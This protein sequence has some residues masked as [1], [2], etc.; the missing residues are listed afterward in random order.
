MRGLLVA[1]GFFCC[2]AQALGMR[3]SVA[4]ARRLQGTG[5]AAVTHGLS[6]SAACGIFPGQGSNPCPC[7]GRW[8][9]NHSAT[10]EAQ[11]LISFKLHTILSSLMKSCAACSSSPRIPNHSCHPLLTSNHQHCHDLN[12]HLNNPVSPGADD[13]HQYIRRSIVA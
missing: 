9:L 10:R 6:C 4:V 11:Q 7:I 5:S 2:G 13:P 3:A 8:I 1:V 12:D